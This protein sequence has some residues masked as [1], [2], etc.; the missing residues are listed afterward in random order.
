[1]N[2][3]STQASQLIS[4][5]VR[6]VEEDQ[7]ISILHIGPVLGDTLDFF[8]QYRC[9]IQVFDMFTELPIPAVE[10]TEAGL[11]SYFDDLLQLPDDAQFDVC[12]F[13]DLF[14]YL[15]TTALPA[16][17]TALKPYLKPGCRGHGYTVHN[18][19]T[20]A[21]QLLYGIRDINTVSIR[22]RKNALPNYAPHSQNTL[23]KLLH[24]FRMERSVLL[25]DRRL[26]LL[27]QA[28]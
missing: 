25:S 4:A 7:R 28:K 22:A 11:E 23:K 5:L 27:L 16:F 2:T 6:G 19:R 21:S 15:D 12:L 10:E 8:S 24:C 20:P 17:L 18:P 13:W 1:V 14:D 3:I 9:R 26:E